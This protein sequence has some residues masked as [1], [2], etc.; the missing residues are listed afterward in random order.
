ML[1]VLN[2]MHMV[3]ESPHGTSLVWRSGEVMRLSSPIEEAGGTGAGIGSGSSGRL[4]SDVELLVI[5]GGGGG[6]AGPSGGKDEEGTAAA[7][8]CGCGK[9]ACLI[10]AEMKGKSK[11]FP[12]NKPLDPVED[13]VRGAKHMVNRI[14]T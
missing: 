1:F 3:T 13:S 14:F 11:M 2:Q 8:G 7:A 5:A 6:E 10:I 4:F 9:A 12:R